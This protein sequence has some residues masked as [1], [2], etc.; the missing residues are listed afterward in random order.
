[1]SNTVF[2]GMVCPECGSPCNREEVD[3]GG[4]FIIS[5]WDCTECSWSADD[6]GFPMLQEDWDN[7]FAEE[8]AAL[9]LTD[10]SCTRT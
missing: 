6:N 5:P 1:M 10:Q 4:G 2:R 8:D 3:V 9:C 7:K